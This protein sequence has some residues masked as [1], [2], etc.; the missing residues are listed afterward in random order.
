MNYGNKI[1]YHLTLNQAHAIIA[2]ADHA[3]CIG[4]PL[5]QFVT[6]HF[7]KAGITATHAFV[8][9]FFKLTGDWLRASTKEPPY[10]VWVLENEQNKGLHLHLL[11]HVPFGRKG[12]FKK[13]ANRWLDRLGT[14]RQADALDIRPVRHSCRMQSAKS[15][16]TI[17]AYLGHWGGWYQRDGLKG[18]L[19]Y[20]LKGLSAVNCVAI[21]IGHQPQGIVTGKR[22]GFSEALGPTWRKRIEATWRQ[23]MPKHPGITLL[24]SGL[25]W[26]RWLRIVGLCRETEYRPD[27]D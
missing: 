18:A 23:P 19:G 3:F 2:A 1:S 24:G 16:S 25:R 4:R 27:V 13:L 21:G 9:A 15:V 26:R 8:T 14:N 12:Q 7:N 17:W 6:I 20:M 11:V 10:Y 5:N 22:C